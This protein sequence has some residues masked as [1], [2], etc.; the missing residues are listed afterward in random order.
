[1]VNP[2]VCPCPSCAKIRKGESADKKL[3]N[4]FFFIMLHFTNSIL[5]KKAGREGK[6]SHD[7]L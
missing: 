4:K 6:K 3:S 5:E 1:M 2:C 7:G